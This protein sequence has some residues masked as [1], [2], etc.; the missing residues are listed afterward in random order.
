MP[1]QVSAISDIPNF[2]EPADKSGVL[3]LC[4]PMFQLYITIVRPKRCDLRRIRPKNVPT[5]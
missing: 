5:T 1:S 3:T 2:M 4:L